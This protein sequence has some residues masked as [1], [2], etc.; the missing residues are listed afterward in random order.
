MRH[1]TGDPPAKAPAKEPSDQ[2]SFRHRR[3]QPSERAEPLAG[4][5]LDRLRGID[6]GVL[7]M[8]GEDPVDHLPGHPASHQFEP[9]PCGTI[10]TPR[11]EPAL[12][13]PTSEG[14]VVEEP[15]G[16]EPLQDD[17][18]LVGGVVALEQ[19]ALELGPGARATREGIEGAVVAA[20]GGPIPGRQN[21]RGWTRVERRGFR[22]PA[23]H[24]RSHPRPK[25]IITS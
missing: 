22:A 24:H 9:H 8:L 7:L 12:D 15:S 16:D 5:H 1:L 17:I 2:P 4:R 23:T 11:P 20:D 3:L 13:E 19:P 10:P 18:D 14:E 6:A 25:G 21:G